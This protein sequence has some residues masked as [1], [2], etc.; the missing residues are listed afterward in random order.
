MRRSDARNFDELRKIQITRNF[1]KYAEGSCL[2]SLGNTK[3]VCTATVD[4]NV[5][6]FLKGSGC[7]WITSEYGMLPRSTQMRILREKISGRNMEI[8]RLIGRSLR[9][10]V[11][12]RNLGERTIWVDCDVIQADGGTR[13]ASII[14]GFIALVDCL[15]KLLKEE[16]IK[17]L[18]LVDLLGAVS[19]GIWRGNYILDLTFEEDSE[20][21]VDMNIVMKAKGEFVEIQGTAE[22]NSFTKKDL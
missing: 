17:K 9:S 10:V 11:D 22:K 19:V 7:G 15:Y 8:Q 14:G 13:I 1:I 18:G 4:K 2:I 12:L 20:A 16:S 21:D 6:S 5:P 3:V